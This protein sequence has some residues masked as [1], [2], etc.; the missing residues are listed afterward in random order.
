MFNYRRNIEEE[1]FINLKISE[2]L[3]KEFDPKHIIGCRTFIMWENSG[4]EAN[5]LVTENVPVQVYDDL[6]KFIMK[7]HNLSNRIFPEKFVVSCNFNIGTYR[8]FIDTPFICRLRLIEFPA[9]SLL[10]R[11]NHFEIREITKK[12]FE[13]TNIIELSVYVDIGYDTNRFARYIYEFIKNSFHD[14]QIEAIEIS[15]HTYKDIIYTI[16]PYLY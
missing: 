1:F 4:L 5:K 10:E 12:Y 11:D 14:E 7:I 6:K 16:K 15:Q 8:I 3:P 13:H 2:P 9:T